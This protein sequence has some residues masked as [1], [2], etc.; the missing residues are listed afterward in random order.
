MRLCQSVVDARTLRQKVLDEIRLIVP[1]DAYAWLLTD[2]ETSVGSSPLADVPCLSGAAALI[3]LKY[4]TEVNRWTRLRDAGRVA[5]G[6]DRGELSRS[7]VWRELLHRYD[8]VDVASVVFRDAFGCWG[9]LDLWR[10]SRAGRF[11]AADAAYLGGI[12]APVTTALRRTQA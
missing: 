5:G 7:L 6:G 11:T 9:F 3:R 12:A 8:V 2:P 10:G 1:F 4:L